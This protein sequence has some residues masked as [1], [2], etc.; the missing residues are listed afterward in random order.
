MFLAPALTNAG[1][2]YNN[3]LQ[4]GYP[5]SELTIDEI[6][7]TPSTY[8]SFGDYDENEYYK[9][10]QNY[11]QYYEEEREEDEGYQEMYEPGTCLAGE[12]MDLSGS[13]TIVNEKVSKN[14]LVTIKMCWTK[15]NLNFK[16]VTHQEQ[17]DFG[18]FAESEEQQQENP[19]WYR[20]KYSYNNEDMYI[21][22][23]TYDYSMRVKVPDNSYT[24][25]ME[26]CFGVIA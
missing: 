17:V 18:Y 16:C 26:E 23:G 21:Y 25:M 20:S 7:C 13:L 4:C 1:L 11:G 15:W 14:F 9:E 8:Y 5:F 19:Y 3:D 10:Q 24:G 6:E 2:T 12:T 22:P